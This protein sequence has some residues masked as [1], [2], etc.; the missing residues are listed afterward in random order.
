MSIH[1]I[2]VYTYNDT[3]PD[4]EYIHPVSRAVMQE[5]WY[6]EASASVTPF[7]TVEKSTDRFD[8]HFQIL[9]LHTRIF[10]PKTNTFAILNM[11][12]STNHIKNRIENSSLKSSLW[13]N[14]G[15]NFYQSPSSSLTALPENYVKGRGSYYLGKMTVD[16]DNSVIG[17]VSTLS[18]SYSDDVFYIAS[19]DY[20]AYPYLRKIT[21]IHIAIIL[22]IL[23]PTTIFVLFYSRYFSHRVVT[24][25]QTMHEVS[26]LLHTLV[27][28]GLA[29]GNS[30]RMHDN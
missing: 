24:L 25:R 20:D 2:S 7:W 21:L 10:L 12:V 3:L 23:V 15:Q 27:S 16:T 13:L 29:T 26:L 18:T 19:L 8:N 14:D 30:L 4:S 28:T 1:D 22:L 5:P 9:T 17:C 11:G 6:K